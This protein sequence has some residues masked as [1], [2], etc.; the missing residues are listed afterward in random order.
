MVY[1]LHINNPVKLL[2]LDVYSCVDTNT[3]C[4]WD[5][6]F[7][8]AL[9]Y[10]DDLILLAPCPSALRTML[11]LCESFANSYGLKF[12]AGFCSAILIP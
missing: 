3:C 12:N 2:K 6:L 11:S 1:R 9:C 4:Y 8:G 5:G 10:A 7:V